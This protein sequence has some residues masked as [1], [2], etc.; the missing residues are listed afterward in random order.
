MYPLYIIKK[1]SHGNPQLTET[2]ID[3]A[4]KLN[5]YDLKANAYWAIKDPS[6]NVRYLLQTYFSKHSIYECKGDVFAISPEAAKFFKP[7]NTGH[8]SGVVIE[9]IDLYDDHWYLLISDDKHYISNVQGTAEGN[10]TFEECI[11]REVKE[12]TQID[13]SDIEPVPI[14]SYTFTYRNA[15]VD[16]EYEVVSQI[17]YVLLPWDRVKHLFKYKD[18]HLTDLTSNETSEASLESSG[19]TVLIRDNKNGL[20]CEQNNP[21]D[22]KYRSKSEPS[23]KHE[24]SGDAIN[25][26]YCNINIIDAS[27]LDLKEKLDEVNYIITIPVKMNMEDVPEKFDIIRVNKTIKGKIKRVSADYSKVSHHRQFIDLFDKDIPVV[28]PPFLSS[29]TFNKRRDDAIK[30]YLEINSHVNL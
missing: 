4:E 18:Q 30:E 27:K 21:S 11:K 6:D 7:E 17:Y 10:E 14:A 28:K 1:N 22:I 20:F 24:S 2:K 8:G 3:G 23:C 26:S 29:I 5:F 15:L 9:F 13:I 12:E 19:F 16:C 25:L